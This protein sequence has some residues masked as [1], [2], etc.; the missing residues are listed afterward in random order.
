MGSC[1]STVDTTDAVRM[2]VEAVDNGSDEAALIHN[3]NM[4]I[5]SKVAVKGFFI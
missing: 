1:V 5:S 2:G 3:G 4:N